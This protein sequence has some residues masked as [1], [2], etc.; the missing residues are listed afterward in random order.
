MTYIA[1]TLIQILILMALGL[2]L[3]LLLGYAGQ[4]S[5]AH[6]AFYGIGAYTAA[7]MTMSTVAVVESQS[8]GVATG[9]GLNHWLAL[10]IAMAVTF[11]FALI[12]SV[13][14]ALRVR[15]ELLILVHA[16]VPAGSRPGHDRGGQDHG[17]P[18]W[19]RSYPGHLALWVPA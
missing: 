17:R 7:L 13:P 1:D 6:A 18:V 9:L 5:M 8:R 12:I 4:V 16:G 10:V 19:A 15:G 3:N 2:S 14:A 11:V